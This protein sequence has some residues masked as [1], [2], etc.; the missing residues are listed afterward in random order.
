MVFDFAKELEC[1][2]SVAALTELFALKVGDLGVD[3]FHCGSFLGPD[4][5]L[6]L[7][8]TFG[9]ADHDWMV[10]YRQQRYFNEDPA[11]RWGLRTFNPFTWDEMMAR[12][13]LTP[14]EAKVMQDAHD[15]GLRWGL[16]IPLHG[17]DGRVSFFM[18][19][20]RHNPVDDDKR[21]A[22]QL[23]ATV[24]Q[25]RAEILLKRSPLPQCPLTPRQVDV[26]SWVSEG[27]TDSE[28]G[29]ILSISSETAHKHVERA[30]AKLGVTTRTQAVAVA[31]RSGYIR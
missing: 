18:A 30:K 8:P 4:G 23:M 29:H 25:M 9:M 5:M 14:A 13:R 16:S 15:H 7:L 21:L 2:E 10:R 19:A 26:L 1:V 12:S 28:I 11:A 20:G 22:I 27:K 6:Q 24:A 3:F 17:L 31:L